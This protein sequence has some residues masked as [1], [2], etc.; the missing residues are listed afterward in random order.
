MHLIPSVKVGWIYLSPFGKK[1]AKLKGD[2][3]AS[4]DLKVGEANLFY[5][6]IFRAKSC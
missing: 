4:L 5:Q 3:L 1:G 2:W 6:K